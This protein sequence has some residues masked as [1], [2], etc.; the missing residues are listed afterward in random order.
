VDQNKKKTN[1]K[2]SLN[3]ETLRALTM[4]ELDGVQGGARPT[5][6]NACT[7]AGGGIC[8]GPVISQDGCASYFWTCHQQA[9]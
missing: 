4:I 5:L 2:L 7:F 8:P 3:R 6:A 9:C 1:R